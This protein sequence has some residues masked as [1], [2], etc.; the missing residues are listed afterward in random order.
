VYF[1]YQVAV[2]I[3]VVASPP[4][5]ADRFKLDVSWVGIS[6][7][8]AG[9]AGIVASLLAGRYIAA[10]R[11][12]RMMSTGAALV[13]IG[14]AALFALNSVL[15]LVLAFLPLG[16]AVGLLDVGLLT[17]RQSALPS[18]GATGTLAVS[19]SLNLAGYPTGAML[20]GLLSVHGL[21]IQIGTAFAFSVMSLA[22]CKWLPEPFCESKPIRKQT[23]DF[24]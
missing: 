8:I 11:E 19:S 15:G 4:I 7:S 6:W 3:L 12:R 22:M 2:G 5:I 21:N 1:L 23:T 13:V 10:G 20:A 18:S 16:V 14:I 24:P 17:L 9:I